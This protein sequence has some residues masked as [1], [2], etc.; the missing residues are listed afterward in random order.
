MQPDQDPQPVPALV[1]DGGLRRRPGPFESLRDALLLPITRPGK[2]AGTTLP[3]LAIFLP[4][5]VFFPGTC[6]LGFEFPTVGV[7]IA[8][9]VA[10][11]EYSGV[12]GVGIWLV[13][14]FLTA[15]FM[16]GWSLEASAEKPYSVGT[17]IA[18]GWRHGLSYLGA[19]LLI[20]LS[21]VPFY[22]LS[23]VVVAIAGVGTFKLAWGDSRTYWVAILFLGALVTL[24]VMLRLFVLPAL[25]I[26]RGW[27]G[28][29]LRLAWRSSRGLAFRFLC[30]MAVMM[31]IAFIV[32]WM[33]GSL[34]A[35]SMLPLGLEWVA[36]A[37]NCF[38]LALSILVSSWIAALIG[39]H[40]PPQALWSDQSQLAVF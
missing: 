26:L 35:P 27:R 13:T 8:S 16:A 20:Y 30:H 36:I 21:V 29:V 14:A 37:M 28:G 9:P 33:L 6:I 11:F 17:L 19:M 32:A 38:S 22:L 40:V 39:L 3:L 34:V 25:V 12:I 15:A 2:F 23:L 31:C 4:I 1:P 5:T 18:F 7:G 24:W 10:V